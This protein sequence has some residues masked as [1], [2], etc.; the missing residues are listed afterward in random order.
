VIRIVHK[1]LDQIANIEQLRV[2]R[3][4]LHIEFQELEHEKVRLAVHSATLT[5]DKA[6]RHQALQQELAALP[7]W[8][9]YAVVTEANQFDSVKQ[10]ALLCLIKSILNEKYL[11]EAEVAQ[12][13]FK[14]DTHQD[15]RY[16]IL[17]S[18]VY[19]VLF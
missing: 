15:T 12:M 19:F 8:P 10:N 18:T 16:K 11:M 3:A 13:V 1:C 6:A 9:H 17:I 4:P 5:S 14:R 2:V 7:V